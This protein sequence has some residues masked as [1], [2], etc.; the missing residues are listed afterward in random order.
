MNHPPTP[1][2]SKLPDR[3]WVEID[4]SAIARNFQRVKA[5]FAPGAR[6][7]PVI[8][9]DA[10]GH[11][12]RAAANALAPDPQLSGFA[13]A[14]PSEAISLR[15]AGFELP[16]L[17]FAPMRGDTLRAA[18]G[19]GL[20]VTI[21]DPEGAREAAAAAKSLGLVARAHLKVDTGMGRMGHFPSIALE[22]LDA[23]RG[24]DDLQIEA[25]YS[26]M[27]D[28]WENPDSARAQL[29]RMKPV[30]DAAGLP[31]HWGGS[32]V[33]SMAGQLGTSPWIRTG[34]ALY[35]DH[36]GY[37]GLEPAMTFKSRVLFT[38]DVP[39][40]ATISYGS[41]YVTAKP[42]RLAVV[43]AGYGAGYLR[44]LSNRAEILLGGRR[45][46]VLGRVCMDQIVVCVDAGGAEPGDEAVLFGRQG[47]VILPVGEVAARAGTI[48][49]ELMCLAGGLNPGKSV[50]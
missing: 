1:G 26:H 12:W 29:E 39:A 19:E 42:E 25:V 8:K 32:D 11:G 35:G 16:I 40:G 37:D 44:S 5:K 34:I 48:S 31:N 24:G 41:T 15:R 17:I 3:T 2:N 47:D 49:Y 50:N 23:M 28:A 22:M 14:T 18:I 6:F 36:P 30:L 45:C 7:M 9:R 4:A 33:V 43:G 27:A 20:T 13:V 46:P 10:Y 21:A 38:R